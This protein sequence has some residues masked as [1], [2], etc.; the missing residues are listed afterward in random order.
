[1]KNKKKPPR[2]FGEAVD[3]WGVFTNGS[4]DDIEFE[5]LGPN[6]VRLTTT[7]VMEGH[8]G[9]YTG[10][11]DEDPGHARATFSGILTCSKFELL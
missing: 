7:Y 8:E 3:R 9:P 4:A 1:M 2:N 5:I 11:D 6:R 10:Y